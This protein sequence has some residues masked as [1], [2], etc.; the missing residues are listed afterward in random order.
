MREMKIAFIYDA[1]YPWVK[2]GVEKRI[3]ELAVRLAERHEVHIYGVKWWKGK[4]KIEYNNVI[5][6][7]VCKPLELYSDGRRT[8]REAVYFAAKLL[9]ELMKENFDVIDCQEFPYFS[10]FSSKVHTAIKNSTLVVTWHEVW[11]DYWFRYLGK[12]GIFGKRIEN[13]TAKVSRYNIAVSHRTKKE[14]ERLG[15]ESEVIPNGIDF[16]KIVK[17][18]PSK[19]K[20]DVVFA[21]RLIKD[22]NVDLLIEAVAILKK[23]F[24]DVR[25]IIIGDGPE[26]KR[27]LKKARGFGLETNI[28]FTGF[29]EYEQLIS[30]MKSSRV[31]V[32]PSTREGFGIAV[33]EANACGLPV[34]TVKH[35]KNASIE[36]VRDGKNGFLSEFSAVDVAEKIKAGIERKK[37]MQRTCIAVAKKFDWDVIAESAEDCYS[38]WLK[39]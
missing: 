13:L 6:H 3:H 29:M 37:R 39:A 17:M 2:G 25:C 16:K 36:V 34:I 10:C 9:P 30:H 32:L 22:K 14:L 38:S 19:E 23:E 31:F 8:I 28:R 26:K 24:S 4:D 1:V 11:G 7:G 33:I 35:E 12:L 18:G 21:G 27:L 20:S 5:I 15:V